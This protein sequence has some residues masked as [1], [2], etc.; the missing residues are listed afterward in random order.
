MSGTADAIVIGAGVIGAAT[1]FELA[2]QG[3]KVIV[4]DRNSPAGHGS[5]AGSCAIIRMHYSTWDGTALAWEGYH[6]WRDW[7]D[8][9]GLP[10]SAD[11][12]RFIETG[13]LV[14]QTET[15]GHLEKHMSYSSQIGR[16]SCRERV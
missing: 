6:Y 16:A 14:M 12:A 5:T 7:R 3:R 10:A 1:A 15:N 4:V 8:Y 9:L 13:C 2:K 11:L